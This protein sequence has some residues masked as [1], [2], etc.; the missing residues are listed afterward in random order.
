MFLTDRLLP[1]SRLN[2]KPLEV[3]PA[4]VIVARPTMVRAASPCGRCGDLMRDV[5]ITGT[6]AAPVRPSYTLTFCRS[7]S[8]SPAFNGSMPASRAGFG[9]HGLIDFTDSSYLARLGDN[10][11][12]QRELRLVVANYF[13]VFE[14]DA[15]SPVPWPWL[16]GDA[17]NNPPARTPVSTAP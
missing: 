17:M 13:R 14:I 7:S 11:P 4:W 10:G 12:A 16:Y 5:A 1:R 9:W 15:W 6:L 2:G 3:V 8:V